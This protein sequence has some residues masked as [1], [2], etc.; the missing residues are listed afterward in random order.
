[1]RAPTMFVVAYVCIILLATF[2]AES[3]TKAIRL[4]PK[5]SAGNAFGDIE[6]GSDGDSEEGRGRGIQFMITQRMKRTLVN[7]LGYDEDEVDDME[8][9]IAA[10]VIEKKLARPSKGMPESW[11]VNGRA[12]KRRQY[13]QKLN[14][15]MKK[16]G[17]DLKDALRKAAPFVLPLVVAGA[18]IPLIVTNT[19][20]VG[21]M[22]AQLKRNDRSAS[23]T[24]SAGALPKGMKEVIPN[25][26]KPKKRKSASELIQ[27]TKFEKATRPSILDRVAMLKMSI[28]G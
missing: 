11:K 13:Y 21:A 4:S 9:Q 27:L 19:K 24:I 10:V 1:M 6:D 20:N 12:N 7:E 15:N 3:T 23:T 25:V 22:F 8:P 17:E 5:Q 26:K 2:L 16:F 28:F 18:S 14:K